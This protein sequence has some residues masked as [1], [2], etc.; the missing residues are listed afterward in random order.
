MDGQARL[1]LL[2]GETVLL[3]VDVVNWPLVANTLKQQTMVNVR[4]V[5]FAEGMTAWDSPDAYKASHSESRHQGVRWI[6][7]T[8]LFPEEKGGTGRA[9][10]TI[11]GVVE[12]AES[13]VN[14]LTQ[15]PFRWLRLETSG[16][17]LDVVA[18]D[19]PLPPVGGIVRGHF[20]L[21]SHIEPAAP[22]S[23][24]HVNVR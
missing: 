9:T 12:Q 14:G 7:P 23:L 17:T 2:P 4:L 10:A 5:A 18:A 22:D 1:Y 16:A 8:G 11:T 15:A 20:W 21:A 6:V 19:G 3:P 24:L 13:R